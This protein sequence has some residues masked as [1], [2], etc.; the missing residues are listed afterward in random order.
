MSFGHQST[1]IILGSTW[2]SAIHSS[3][4]VNR[5]GDLCFTSP[6]LKN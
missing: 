4:F 1:A 2:R 5:K 3:P 6:S